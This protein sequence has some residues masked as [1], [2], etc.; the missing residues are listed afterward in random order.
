MAPVGGG[1]TAFVLAGGGTKGAFETGAL[2]YLLRD[3][4][5]TPDIVTAASAG[6]VIG[7][8]LAQARTRDEFVAVAGEIRAD[9][10]A[11]T[12]VK[13]V[14]G[15]QPWLEHFEDTPF[16]RAIDEFVTVRRRPAP[17]NLDD[18]LDADLDAD[19]DADAGA[20]ERRR[21][22]HH[23]MHGLLDALELLPHA[24]HA[25]KDL[26][27]HRGS[28]LTLEPLHRSL[29]GESDGDFVPIDLELIARPGLS[30]RI[31]VTALGAGEVRY[32]TELG[33][34]VGPDAVTPIPAD[35]PVDLVD[36]V[37]ASSSVPMIFPPRRM[38]AEVY[39]DGG[40]LQNVPVD[41]AVRLGATRIVA[42]LAAPLEVP[43]D[44]RDFT[45]VSLVSVF[46]RAMA[47]ISLVQRQRDNLG[48]P[49]PDDVELLV[50][51]P[52]VDVVG[53]FDVS[54]GLMLIDMAYGW[55]RAADVLAEFDDATRDHAMRLS[56]DVTINRER[57]WYLEERLWAA[58]RATDAELA[59][60]RRVKRA[61]QAG[62]AEREALG[63][64]RSP[65]A[66]TWWQAH[67]GHDQPIPDG[68]PADLWDG[69]VG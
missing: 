15:K 27:G 29:R 54:K 33:A 25:R 8:V 13:Y 69:E 55:M 59:H 28:L 44:D 16:G 21:A 6:S 32:V 67:E 43:L 49:R 2:E 64:P 10:L 12:D 11:L 23:R 19:A 17:P 37:V 60:L 61:V 68:L 39:A 4:G 14:F 53:P 58:G 46:V 31:A 36:A 3:R 1:R 62:V 63:L 42:I 41:P 65:E 20:R 66:D 56:D 51:A 45:D 40:V 38:G 26:P 5:I 35:G 30:L 9:L 24:M 18:D 50:I 48:V 52:T 22:R 47:S 57:A 34:V 7:A